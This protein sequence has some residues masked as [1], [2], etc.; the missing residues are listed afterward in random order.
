[1]SCARQPARRFSA[2]DAMFVVTSCSNT[3][4]RNVK[5]L[6]V[7]AVLAFCMSGPS[8]A[9]AAT[10][11]DQ[12]F[13]PSD[14]RTTIWAVV[15]DQG[16]YAHDI[17]PAQTFTVGLTGSLSRIEFPRWD[18]GSKSPNELTW[19]VRT[20]Q[21]SGLPPNNVLLS[22]VCTTPSS[23]T[24][25]ISI[26]IASSGGL[27][28]TAGQRLAILLQV[29]QLPQNAGAGCEIHGNNDT[30]FPGYTLGAKCGQTT[31]GQWTLSAGYDLFFRTYVESVPEPSSL[32]AISAGLIPLLY[33]RRR[34]S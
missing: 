30:Y 17:R 10:V 31:T 6:Y 15:G 1:M 16:T 29:A 4:R 11:L 19:S 22:G 14:R 3:R 34:R 2:T 25:P 32:L 33:L 20:I 26:S 28:V 8:H 18:R 13:C 27:S 21:P 5:K 9:S 24:T 7:L 23:N 12:D